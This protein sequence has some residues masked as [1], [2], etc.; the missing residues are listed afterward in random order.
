MFGLRK[1]QAPQLRL[2]SSEFSH[3]RLVGKLLH[4]ET[5]IYL[6]LLQS[7]YVLKHKASAYD[8]WISRIPRTPT[9]SKSKRSEIALLQI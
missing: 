8:V 6:F 7:P 5:K 2:L 9:S 1:K 3:T 4:H